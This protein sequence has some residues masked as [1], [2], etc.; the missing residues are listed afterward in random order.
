MLET[1][2]PFS[3]HADEHPVSPWGSVAE[4]SRDALGLARQDGPPDTPAREYTPAGARSPQGSNYSMRSRVSTAC[5]FGAVLLG[6]LA[7]APSVQAQVRFAPARTANS[8]IEQLLE[9]GQQY[10]SRRS[11]GEALTLYED[12]LRQHPGEQ[13]IEERFLQSKIHY[14]LGRRYGDDSFRRALTELSEAEALALYNEVLLKIQANY[15]DRPI[16][17]ALVERGADCLQ[18][19]LSDPPFAERHLQRATPKQIERFRHELTRLMAARMVRSRDDAREAVRAA[20]RL[21]NMHLA[22][23]TTATLFEFLCGCTLALDDYSTYLT[24]DQLNEV[25]SQIDGNFVGLGIELK[26]SGGSLLI[27]KVIPGSPAERG[28]IHAGD[29]ILSVDGTTT[30]DLSTDQ[31]A[32]LLQGEEGT[33]VAVTVQSEGAAPRSIRLHR[34]QVDVPSVDDVK[35]VDRRH[36][37]GYLKLTCFQKT[38]LRDLDSALWKLQRQGMQSLI[39]DLRGNPGGLLT[40]SVEVVDK[41][42]DEGVIVSTRGRNPH[43]DASYSAHRAGT[44]RVPLVVLIDGDSASAS[45]IFAGAIRDHHRGTII[46][47]R[48]YGK[49]SV[50][51]I[52]PLS[53][54]RA[55]IRLTTAKFYS[56]LGHPYSKRGVEP[57]MAVHA[58]AK[59]VLVAT[60]PDLPDDDSADPVLERAVEVARGQI[61]RR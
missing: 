35:L 55:G 41:F 11:W 53:Y 28:G 9:R 50:Q 45:E 1:H 33:P 52:F 36:Q 58:S 8:E 13:R 14:D 49:G 19:A 37:V 16:W 4:S 5:W 24:A 34:E 40:S 12:A 38:T 48:S 15:V 26:A 47:A 59:P 43:E 25:Y 51:G 17:S 60:T 44:W 21:A 30:T 32:D 39:I 23:P 61:A 54:A 56:P 22:I 6:G 42:L 29:R 10:E 57:D 2:D 27:V 20:A 46:G 3:P 7:L 18:I 31:A